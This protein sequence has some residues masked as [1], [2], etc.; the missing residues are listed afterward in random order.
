MVSTPSL[1]RVTGSEKNLQPGIMSVSTK[2]H[3]VTPF[4]PARPA[5]T[6]SAN[7]A[8]VKAMESVAEP[9]PAFAFTTSSPPNMM[10]C[11]RASRSSSEKLTVGSACDRSGTM[12]VPAWPPITGTLTF[13]GSLPLAPPTKVCARHTSRVVTPKS[14]L[15]LY[16]PFDFS[17]SAAI[18]TVELTGLEMI[19]MAALGQAS[20]QPATKFFTMPALMLN[21][22][23]RV[24][25]G[26]RGTPAGITTT[27]QPSRALVSSSPVK[28]VHEELVAMWERSAATPGV[29]GA[30]SKHVSA[31]TLGLIFSSSESG[32]P[33]PPAAPRTLH[34]KPRCCWARAALPT[35]RVALRRAENMAATAAQATGLTC[36]GL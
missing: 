31:V 33:M 7:W 16:T 10:R 12:V 25:P 24:M 21:R 23:S 1:P 26:L 3:S 4:S 34:L 35:E 5:M 20:A 6:R 2:V 8:P 36:G 32:W 29:M 30:T 19:R 22:S 14:F 11:V 15:G 13:E 17:T 18:G 9:P 28:P 27:S